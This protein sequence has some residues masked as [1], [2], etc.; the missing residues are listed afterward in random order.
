M[1]TIEESLRQHYAVGPLLYNPETLEPLSEEGAQCMRWLHEELADRIR[2]GF[3]EVVGMED[4]QLV[5][6]VTGLQESAS[7]IGSWAREADLRPQ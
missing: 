5:Y 7:I 6:E 4:G 2:K 3:L 1:T